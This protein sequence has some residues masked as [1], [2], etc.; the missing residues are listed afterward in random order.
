M[1]CQAS[2]ERVV[3]FI[4]TSLQVLGLLVSAFATS[5]PHLILGFGVFCGL[6]TGVV[7]INSIFILNKYFRARVSI[8][9]G[10]SGALVSASGER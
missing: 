4:G 5:T 6:G 1:S 10:L 9:I 8:A 3:A 2:S 7:S